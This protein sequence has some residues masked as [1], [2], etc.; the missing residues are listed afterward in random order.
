[1]RKPIMAGNWKMNKTAAEGVQL[2]NEMK[3]DLLDVTSVDKVFCPPYLAVPDVA[4]AVAGTDLHV[5][6]QDLYWEASGA[7]TG[8]VAPSMVREFCEYVII[9]HSERH[10][11]GRR[12][13]SAV[14]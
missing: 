8:E 9:G 3:A 7:F 2:I 1:M 10:P 5:G 4:R 6:A 12:R 14:T 13:Y 11:P